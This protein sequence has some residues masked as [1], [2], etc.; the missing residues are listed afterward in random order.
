MKNL[1]RSLLS[2][3]EVAEL[4]G[5]TENTVKNWRQ[6]R[7]L[8]YFKAPGSSRKFYFRDE[9]DEFIQNYTKPRKEGA[10]HSKTKA[11]K[12]KPRMSSNPDKDWR[13]D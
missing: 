13:I 1:Q 6:Q 11:L 3:K 9:I 4:F 12:G 2:Q 7:L 8:S 10:K 5:V